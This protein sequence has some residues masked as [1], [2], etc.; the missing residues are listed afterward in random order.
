M[1]VPQVRGVRIVSNGNITCWADA[2]ANLET[3]G[4]DGVMSAEVPRPHWLR[5]AAC[6]V[7]CVGARAGAVFVDAR[8]HR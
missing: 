3:T 7:P 1:L 8:I 4:A 6:T 2:L 5:T